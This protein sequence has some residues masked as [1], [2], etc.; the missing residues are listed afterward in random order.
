MG[1]QAQGESIWERGMTCRGPG[2]VTVWRE[3]YS[4]ERGKD[5]EVEALG[6]GYGLGESDGKRADGGLAE[7]YG[8]GLMPGLWTG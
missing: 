3:G 6:E 1:A 2:P 7:G 5:G 4:L 8:C